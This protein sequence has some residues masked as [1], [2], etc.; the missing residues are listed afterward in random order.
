MNYVAVTA[1]S[2]NK[3]KIR[4]KGI[5]AGKIMSTCLFSSFQRHSFLSESTIQQGQIT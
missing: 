2:K 4:E 5:I 1:K 3:E